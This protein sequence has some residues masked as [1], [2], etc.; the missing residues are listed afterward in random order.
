IERETETF[1]NNRPSISLYG[2]GSTYKLLKSW[3]KSDCY[4]ESFLRNEISQSSF[5]YISN[6]YN[7]NDLLDLF[8]LE[9]N[10]KILIATT[11]SGYG[12]VGWFTLEEWIYLLKRITDKEVRVHNNNLIYRYISTLC[13]KKILSYSEQ[14][15]ENE[16]LFYAIDPFNL[17]ISTHP[18]FKNKS[19]TNI[20]W[21]R[22]EDKDLI[23]SSKLEE[24][25]M[26]LIQDKY[27]GILNNIEPE[28]LP[29]IPVPHL[30]TIVKLPYKSKPLN[31]VG[32]G[33]TLADVESSLTLNIIRNYFYNKYSDGN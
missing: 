22:V 13:M 20:E 15:K 6:E 19:T 33:K 21:L 7:H 25:D 27:I 28:K 26:E 30:S 4:N 24:I 1:L 16:K 3:L 10:N 23:E 31:L 14:N 32:Y 17:E 2:S 8:N 29:Q 18:I 12:I 5:V 11:I 9:G